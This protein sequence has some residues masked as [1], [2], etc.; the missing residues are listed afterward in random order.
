M[1]IIIIIKYI[2]FIPWGPSM[3]C[4]PASNWYLGASEWKI[5]ILHWCS[6]HSIVT[7]SST[8]KDYVVDYLVDLYPTSPPRRDCWAYLVQHQS[9]SISV[10]FNPQWTR[11]YTKDNSFDSTTTS[12]NIHGGTHGNMESLSIEIVL[13]LFIDKL[14]L[15]WLVTLPIDQYSHPGTVSWNKNHHGH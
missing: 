14:L 5:V 15:N 10:W 9:I 13:P 2:T 1:I 8:H 3:P 12:I 6:Y 11:S 7:S 4:P